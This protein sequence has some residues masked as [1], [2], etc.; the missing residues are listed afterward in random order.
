MAK[1]IDVTTESFAEKV[2][3]SNV[4]VLV[5]F[6]APWCGPCRQ[7]APIL[8][9]VADE[10]D[11]KLVVAKVNVDNEPALAAKFGIIS[12]PTMHLFT[13]GESVK[14][15]VGGRSKEKLISEISPLLGA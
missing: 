10:L 1:V 6:W 2:I 7:I 5:D 4:P 14:T 8:E 3:N 12:I 15:I 13:L 11:G 9:Q